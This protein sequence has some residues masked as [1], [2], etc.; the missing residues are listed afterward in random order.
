MSAT[1]HPATHGPRNKRAPIRIFTDEPWGRNYNASIL[2]GG[3][4]LKISFTFSYGGAAIYFLTPKRVE[5]LEEHKKRTAR[6]GLSTLDGTLWIPTHLEVHNFHFDAPTGQTSDCWLPG[7]EGT[8]CN[9]EL[10]YDGAQSILDTVWNDE[11]EQRPHN[12]CTFLF[13]T[14]VVRVAAATSGVPA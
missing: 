6:R 14:Y 8:P 12:L 11:V 4:G 10:T 1:W 7:R 9:S 5:A 13:D 3:G 2:V